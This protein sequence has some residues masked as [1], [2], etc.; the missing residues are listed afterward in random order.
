MVATATV[1]AGLPAG[2]QGVLVGKVGEE[3]PGVE[4]AGAA[5]GRLVW[6]SLHG[7]F[8]PVQIE[9]RGVEL[10]RAIA[11]VGIGKFARDVARR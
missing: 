3:D 4:L 6:I 8:A 9:Q 10:A 11:G 1:V 2:W 5:S 7:A